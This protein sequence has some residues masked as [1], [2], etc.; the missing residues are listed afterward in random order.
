MLEMEVLGQ[1]YRLPTSQKYFTVD[2]MTYLLAEQTELL[3]ENFL[4]TASKLS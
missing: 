2:L 3:K 4:A 1:W